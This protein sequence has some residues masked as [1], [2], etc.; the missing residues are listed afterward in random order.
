MADPRA[1]R[2]LRPPAPTLG[3]RRGEGSPGAILQGLPGL[4]AGGTNVPWKVSGIGCSKR[5]SATGP[6]DG[7]A[8]RQHGDV[9][10]V[11]G[12]VVDE[13]Q[14]VLADGE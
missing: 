4:D 12:R 7:S 14:Q 6:R 10:G 1:R 2:G 9:R 11:A 3:L 8:R 13:R 5:T